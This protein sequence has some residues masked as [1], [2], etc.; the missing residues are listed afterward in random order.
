V[1]SCRVVPC[2]QAAVGKREGTTGAKSGKAYLPWAF[3]E[4]AGLCLRT[5]P[6]G[7]KSRARFET[8]HGQGHALTGFAPP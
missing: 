3:S 4:A 2:A 7:H 8:K 1:S 6:A 5:H